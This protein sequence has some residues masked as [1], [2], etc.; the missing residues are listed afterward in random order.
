MIAAKIYRDEDSQSTALIHALRSRGV[1][2]LTTSEAGMGRRPDDDQLRFAANE[3]RVF[4][5][6]NV[7][8]FARLH[9]EWLSTGRSHS[10]I[11]LVRQQ[12]W[13]PG[14]LA[15]IRL[16]TERGAGNMGSQVEFLHDY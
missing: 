1:A 2:V 11:I 4:V 8:D 6:S 14:D 12:K 7:A 3:E 15:L 9:R 5:T 13:S 10:G 16:L